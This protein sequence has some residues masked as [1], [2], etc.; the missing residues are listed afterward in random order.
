M[1]KV[2]IV[3]AENGG[4]PEKYI[5]GIYPTE[6]LARARIAVLEDENGDYGFEYVWFDEV[7]VEAEGADCEL[8]NR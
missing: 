1:T 4:A 7:E 2:F 5:M 8:C 3:S 6:E